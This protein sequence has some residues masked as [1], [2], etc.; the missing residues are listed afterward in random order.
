[1]QLVVGGASGCSARRAGTWGKN[2]P[3]A[4]AASASSHGAYAAVVPAAL[5]AGRRPKVAKANVPNPPIA[6]QAMGNQAC[7]AVAA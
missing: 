2:F 3:R 4:S 7:G 1:M 6:K 5:R